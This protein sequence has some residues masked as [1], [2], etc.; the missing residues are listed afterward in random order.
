VL[1]NVVLRIIRRD[2]ESDSPS[3]LVILSL[4]RNKV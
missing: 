2:K 1:K 3:L 4:L